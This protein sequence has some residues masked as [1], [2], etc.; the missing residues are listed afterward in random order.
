M[1]RPVDT[2]AIVPHLRRWYGTGGA[3]PGPLQ[4]KGRAQGLRDGFVWARADVPEV[5][6]HDAS[7]ALTHLV[8]W[9]EEPVPLSSEFRLE[10]TGRMR[11]AMG[12]RAE[13]PAV[14][15]QFERLEEEFDRHDGPLPYWDAF[16]ADRDG[17]VWLREY[18][19]PGWPSRKWRIVSRRGPIGW[20][21]LP[22]VAYVL[23]IAQDRI[24][25]VRQDELRV[26]AAVVFELSKP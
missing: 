18:S 10:Y 11:E 12:G 8:R 14:A 3:S 23:D 2:L 13:G 21:E 7:G 17:N 25:A 9:N 24:L 26:S 4:V 6:W 1:V 20:V 16:V 22:D 15:R 19:V 5:R